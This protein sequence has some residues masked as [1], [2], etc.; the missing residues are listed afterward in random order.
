MNKYLFIGLDYRYIEN[1]SISSIANIGKMTE[2]ASKKYNIHIES[3]DIITDGCDTTHTTKQ[4]ILMR[5][6]KI[7]LDTW[8]QDIKTVLIYYTGDSMNVQE[9]ISRYASH[10]IKQG[11]V[12]SDYYINGI[13]DKDDLAQIFHQY[14]PKTQIIFIADC[15][16]TCNNIL[17]LKYT[18]DVRND[19]FSITDKSYDFPR[20][21]IMTISYSLDKQSNRIDDNYFMALNLNE[22]ISSYADYISKLEERNNSI[23]ELLQD[24][25]EI[26]KR[27]NINMIPI[28]SA[29]YLPD[30]ND[31]ISDYLIASTFEDYK[32]RS[33]TY[34][35]FQHNECY[36]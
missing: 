33:Y 6:Y 35:D 7:G 27:K 29:S 22:K 3:D 17:D 32:R 34:I 30:I 11:I 31:K 28:M 1:R 9:Y 25:Y 19:A 20:R 4:A 18:W 14:N 23:F 26:F 15:C 5:L 10:H 13:I 8:N 2:Y 16:F 36:C 12:P 24:I 21:K